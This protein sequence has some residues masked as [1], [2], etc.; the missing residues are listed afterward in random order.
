VLPA[1]SDVMLSLKE[2]VDAVFGRNSSKIVLRVLVR[3]LQRLCF[4]DCAW[5][6][7]TSSSL[8]SATWY[9]SNTSALRVLVRRLQRLC[10]KDCAWCTRTSS[11]LSSA[12]WYWSN[13]SALRVL[14]RR[15][16]RLC[17]LYSYGVF[18]IFCYLV[19]EQYKY[20]IAP[21]KNFSCVLI[22][23]STGAS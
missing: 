21:V 2:D 12:I 5:C 8:S 11:S 13:T 14:V 7:R 6:T 3:R 4:K 19:L 1:S 23:G 9:W 15:L 18:F 20:S 22:D 16:Q 10:F 17:L